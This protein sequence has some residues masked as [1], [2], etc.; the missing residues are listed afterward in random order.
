MLRF[1]LALMFAD[2]VYCN[3]IFLNV[4]SQHVIQDKTNESSYQVWY[5]GTGMVFLKKPKM[6]IRWRIYDL[7]TEHFHWNGVSREL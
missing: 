2:V 1:N 5:F 4:N 6:C 3:D 7:P